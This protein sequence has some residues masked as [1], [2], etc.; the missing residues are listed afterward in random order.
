MLEKTTDTI[1]FE[2]YYFKKGLYASGRIECT[3]NCAFMHSFLCKRGPGI[4]DHKI[5]RE[6]QIPDVGSQKSEDRARSQISEVIGKSIENYRH[7]QSSIS[8]C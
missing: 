8:P 1:I 4:R 7:L 2:K 3:E 5:K 6:D